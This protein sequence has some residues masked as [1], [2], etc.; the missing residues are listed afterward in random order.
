M[1]CII[2]YQG[3]E[4]KRE[5]TTFTK[6]LTAFE[7]KIKAG[8]GTEPERYIGKGESKTYKAVVS[9]T[10]ISGNYEWSVSDDTILRITP[11]GHICS[12]KGL[13][14]GS[15]ALSVKFTLEGTD[16]YA[17]DNIG[18]NIFR[19]DIVISDINEDTEEETGA[20]IS[21][22]STRN[23]TIQIEGVLPENEE[24]I[25]SCDNSGKLSLWDGSIQ[26]SFPYTCSISQLPKT[27]T[28]KGE[29]T[30]DTIKDITLTLTTSK[31]GQD[32]AKVTVFKIDLDWADLPDNEKTEDETG[33]YIPLNVDDDNNDTTLDKN[34]YP[35]CKENDL[36]KL[37]IRQPLPS[38]LPGNIYLS[39]LYGSDKIKLWE[40]TFIDTEKIIEV[41]S[42]SY[43]ISDELQSD[44]WLWA[45]GYSKSS[46]KEIE[47]KI[48][49]TTPDGTIT[50]D[51][52]KATIIIGSVLID[53]G[54]G[55]T[56]PGAIGPTGLKE[57]DVNLDIGLR[58]KTLLENAEVKVYMTRSLDENV[59]LDTRN[60]ITIDC[61]PTF[62]FSIHNN[63]S[64][65]NSVRGTET[66]T[67]ENY[68]PLEDIFANNIQSKV[69][70]I[71]QENDRGVKRANYQVLR[72]DLNGYTDGN[73]VE[74]T[75]ISNPIS[76]DRLK[77]PNF[78]QAV[79]EGMK[80][81]ILKVMVEEIQYPKKPNP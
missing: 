42:R 33:L 64:E 44:T 65:N 46:P 18:I 77:D 62:F 56:A 4:I 11:G 3:N 28:L 17:Q 48:S 47:I 52:V 81:A 76:E 60:Q 40:D 58:L 57:K 63:S 19:P 9:P 20:Y 35:V 1:T 32:R 22:G 15:S 38:N 36:R 55:G 30:S 72:H 21:L 12:V 43:N 73:L 10:G 69:H 39:I 80:K 2:K 75:F 14:K 68:Y 78:R 7:V 13:E 71:V 54:H 66:Y 70:Q 51:R 53:P 6:N 74:V 61:K 67:C 34:Q 8:D 5:T 37:I 29:Q 49:Y 59:S 25:L 45:E 23:I 16:K 26:K 79:A 50:D 31:G 24:V 41:T 27:L